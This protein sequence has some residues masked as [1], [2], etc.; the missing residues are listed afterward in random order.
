MRRRKLRQHKVPC[1]VNMC[2]NRFTQL[3]EEHG[4]EPSSSV[5]YCILLKDYLSCLNDSFIT[6]LAQ[7]EFHSAITAANQ[8]WRRF[9]CKKFEGKTISESECQFWGNEHLE[10]RRHKRKDEYDEYENNFYDGDKP[11]EEMEYI[12]SRNYDYNRKCAIFGH[13]HLNRF[14]TNVP[15]NC[16]ITGAYPLF[17]SRF[18]LV[19]VTI[20]EST[21][22]FDGINGQFISKAVAV[23]VRPREGC[24]PIQQIYLA[25]ASDSGPI[26]GTFQDGTN[27][28]GEH[29][30][31][32]SVK[33]LV[34]EEGIRADV[35]LYHLDTTV[36]IRK[37]GN[38]FL[39]V[40][41]EASTKLL[42]NQN[43]HHQICTHGC[44]RRNEFKGDTKIDQPCIRE[45]SE[46]EE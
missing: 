12:N 27:E 33:I 17:D 37:F 6:C 8:N 42:E 10:R 34:Y 21:E 40:F 7:L 29:R 35:I 31:K 5:D 14:Q 41:I 15:E 18:L 46:I 23:I 3:L 44:R 38:K 32:R 25:D 19:Q 30:N 36:R 11:E 43:D 20:D 2:T 45:R 28:I 22:K 39:S 1:L 9:N 26:T 16:A 24:V 13:L 4:T